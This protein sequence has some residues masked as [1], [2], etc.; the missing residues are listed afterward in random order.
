MG[1]WRGRF[2]NLQQDFNIICGKI[3]IPQ[4]T[5]PHKNKSQH[6][7]YAEYYDD[8]TKEIVGELYKK[9]IEY[10]GYKFGG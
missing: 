1:R 8:E 10:F 5:L 3:G 7:H 4:Q 9:D 2:E 6:A